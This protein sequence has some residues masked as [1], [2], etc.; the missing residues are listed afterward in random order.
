V[1]VDEVFTGGTLSLDR[2]GVYQVQRTDEG[3]NLILVREETSKTRNDTIKNGVLYSDKTGETIVRYEV[4]DPLKG[5]IPGIA[6]AEL[7]L[8]SDIDFAYYTDS[9]DPELEVRA[10]N[11]WGQRQV[12]TTWW[13]LKNAI[14][15]NYDQSTTEYRQEQW[16]QLFPTA[17]ID[18]Y[19]WTKSPVTPDEYVTAVQSGTII[20]GQE[21]TG[22]PYEILD[23]YDDVQYNWCEEIEVNRNTNQIE[24]YFYF[25]VKN[26]TTTPTIERNYS[27]RQLTDIIKDP[28]AQSID[29]VAA[30]SDSTLLVSS[31]SKSN[32][33]E[34]LIMQVNYDA[35]ASDYHQEFALFAENDPDLV[36]PEWLH[37][38]LRDS[39]AGFTQDTE[40]FDYVEW[41]SGTTYS[42]DRV[43]RSALGVYFRCHITS[44]NNNPD[45]D[46]NNDYW[47]P[48]ELNQN[49]PDG[50]YTGV[51]TVKINTP[52]SIPDRNLHPNVRYGIETRPHQTWF[53]DI[54]KARKVAVDKINN[55]L[56]E[57]NLIDSDLP[58]REEF[59]RSFFVGG[60]EYDI[61]QYWNFVDWS[62]SGS[63]FERGVGDYFVEF[64]SELGNLTP[65]EGQVAQVENSAD[66]DGRRR[67]SVWQ[68]TG[69]EWVNVY[70][71]K[72]TIRFN[73]LLW[74]TTAG[75]TGWDVENWDTDEWDKSASAVMIEIFD[76]FFN[77]MW[78]E[79][80]RSLYS[81]LWFDLV[82]HVM[83]EQREPD[84]I[85]K[86]SYFK[87]VVEDTLEK[88]YNKF[89]SDGADDFFD[90]VE[91]VKPFRSKL[92]DG[93]IRKTADDQFDFDSQDAV[94][95]RVQTNPVGETIDETFTRSFRLSVGNQGVNYSSQIV[96]T[97]K[98]LVGINLTSDYNRPIPIINVA[99]E[100]A[101]GPGPGAIWINGERIEYESSATGDPFFGLGSGFTIGFDSGMN[102]DQTLPS[103]GFTASFTTG[104]SSG[105]NESFTVLFGITRGTQGT[106]ARPHS[107]ADI[108]EDEYQ[109]GL[110][111]NGNLSDYGDFT[112]GAGGDLAPAWN[113]LG[114]GL[115]DVANLDPNGVT[116]RTE[117][118]GTIFPYGDILLTQ[119]VLQQQTATAIESLQSE[120][121]EL[122]EV[123]WTEN[124]P[125]LTAD[126]T[127][128]DG[129]TTITVD[130]PH[131][132]TTTYD[133][134]YSGISVDQTEYR[135]DN[136]KD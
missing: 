119:W 53:K 37:I 128:V 85:F 4:Y 16:G 123:Y 132:N 59:E 89:F 74:D 39:L 10:E 66:I 104:F 25:W 28:T 34:D 14:Y 135:A 71:E 3:A 95:V 15:L 82:K 43:V 88:R 67:R 70:K 44:I 90:Y 116:I 117:G 40:T 81:D 126:N 100:S 61:T 58:W 87:M 55:Q 77:Q 103:T 83:H 23:Q 134:D 2:G 60:L 57:I 33:F 8:R 76:S 21:L 17:T 6:A 49:N 30:T 80:R 41:N 124:Y 19:E 9:T 94:E 113:E 48:L 98:A 1:Y 120:L 115:L 12:G 102:V 75:G 121:E 56:S 62:L 114:S 31:L 27:V 52:Q 42:P 130:V 101:I 97:R 105:F 109:L 13:D 20:D 118:F 112:T 73:T 68:Y 127:L 131:D 22:Q 51:D 35:N 136:T 86:S 7:D 72:A 110:T 65:T 36:I 91:T 125:D 79:E 46:V 38:S 47:T 32:G 92:R 24:T 133:A 26:K 63:T 45:G 122:I 93:I 18:V 108:I 69:G 107:F 111:E 29:W 78:V 106:F 129:T 84:W 99:D 96:N 54:E 64:K 50:L 11:A 5:I